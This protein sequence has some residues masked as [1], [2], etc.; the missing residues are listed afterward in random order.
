[1]SYLGIYLTSLV[2]IFVGE[3]PDKTMISTIILAR[4]FSRTKLFIGAG[5]A[6]ISQ[7]IISIV[8]GRLVGT[9][10]RTLVVDVSTACFF[11]LG[12]VVL[13]RAIRNKEEDATSTA[14]V[15][16]K[17]RGQSQLVAAF[18]IVFIAEFGDIT[19]LATI[20]LTA[21]FNSTLM[22]GLGAVSGLLL[23]LSVALGASVVLDR[24]PER[25]LE[26][27]AGGALVV[28][29]ILSLFQ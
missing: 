1:V 8:A 18:L 9:L 13:Y 27:F 6:F 3:L 15:R 5:L 22:V 14:W 16:E 12:G 7:T 4:S 24:I 21:R 19:Q 10:A 25:R 29:G 17:V 23:A 2:V 26:I 28:A 11:I 20:S